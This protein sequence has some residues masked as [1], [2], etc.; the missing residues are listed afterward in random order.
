MSEQFSLRC[1]AESEPT[2]APGGQLRHAPAVHAAQTHESMLRAGSPE[3]KV[4]ALALPPLASDQGPGGQRWCDLPARHRGSPLLSRPC[5]SNKRGHFHLHKHVHGF[6]R[7]AGARW[8]C[9]AIGSGVGVETALGG[10][11][12]SAPAPGVPRTTSGGA[13]KMPV[14]Y[15]SGGDRKISVVPRS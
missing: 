4:P 14:S 7:D 1:R 6:Q 12:A 8:S 11:S 13:G 2:P 9:C 15:A 3:S 5:C 10:P